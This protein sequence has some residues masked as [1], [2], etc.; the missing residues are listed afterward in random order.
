MRFRTA[1]SRIVVVAALAVLA[2]AGLAGCSDSDTS[3]PNAA[4]TSSSAPAV[5]VNQAL[6]EQVPESIRKTGT[7]RV[8]TAPDNA[9]IE[10]V[11]DGKVVGFDVDVINQVATILGL[12][13]TVTSVPFGQ[14]FPGV[15]DGRFDVG[16]RALFDTFSRESKADLVTYFAAGTQWAQRAGGSVDPNNACGLTVAVQEATV[17]A[18]AEVPAKSKACSTLGD[19]PIQVITTDS[20]QAAVD[21]VL[22]G[23]ADAVSADS[24]VTAFAVRNAGGKLVTA[25]NAFDTDPYAFVVAKGST[26]GPAIRGAVQSLID[27][28][29]MEQIASRWGIEEG[30]ITTSVINGATN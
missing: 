7:L 19:K 12:R 9:P 10:F 3:T 26:L 29:A 18:T 27:S 23:K 6:A 8:A 24:P 17:Q 21:A 28:G 2:G 15:V 20:Q 13:T 11:R 4:T 5:T 14:I 25:G 1:V 22:A 30:L 16:A